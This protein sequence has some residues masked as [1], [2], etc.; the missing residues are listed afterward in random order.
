[1]TTQIQSF[2]LYNDF[3]TKFSASVSPSTQG[4]RSPPSSSTRARGV[5][6][7]SSPHENVSPSVQT[8]GLG[9]PSPPPE[10]DDDGLPTINSESVD[11]LLRSGIIEAAAAYASHQPDAE[12]AFFVADLG[13]IYRQYLRWKKALPHV[14]PFYGEWRI[15]A[16]AGTI[17]PLFIICIY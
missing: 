1:M 6:F 7:S 17:V 3:V 4:G 11:S 2:S 15:D 12:A 13:V 5:S 9:L 16:Q 8:F 14:T 10:R